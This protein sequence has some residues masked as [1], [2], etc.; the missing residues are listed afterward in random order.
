M[1]ASHPGHARRCTLRG[2]SLNLRFIANKSKFTPVKPN[3]FLVGRAS[4]LCLNVNSSRQA[5]VQGEVVFGHT[6]SDVS[7]LCTGD[8]P[9]RLQDGATDGTSA[10][11]SRSA[12][13]G[14]L[15]AQSSRELASSQLF[16]HAGHSCGSA[17]RIAFT[18]Q[19]RNNFARLFICFA[20]MFMHAG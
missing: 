20:V 2:A 14:K 5:Q 3:F 19:V 4:S 10:G 15:P 1:A 8:D 7:A 12:S 16:M 17:A 9:G 13:P 18:A 6:A 11:A